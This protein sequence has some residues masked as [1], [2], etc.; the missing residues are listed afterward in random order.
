MP[1][2]NLFLER[3]RSNFVGRDQVAFAYYFLAA[4]FFC[5][6]KETRY[7]LWAKSRKKTLPKG[8]A[9]LIH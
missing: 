8:Q 6:A 5:S 3:G 7:A 2:K 1:S 4:P 9:D